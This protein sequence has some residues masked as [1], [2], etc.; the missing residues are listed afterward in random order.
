M[1]NRNGVS[2]TAA[3][4]AQKH[5]TTNA[6][7]AARYKLTK[8][9]VGWARR[10]LFPDYQRKPSGRPPN[11]AAEQAARWAH[12]RGATDRLAAQRFSTTKHAVGRMRRMLFGCRV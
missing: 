12:K 4:W 6:V 8:Q 9:G 3:R 7:A 1:R 5:N 10:Q 2:F 11:K